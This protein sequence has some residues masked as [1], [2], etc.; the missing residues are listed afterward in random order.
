MAY[1]FD[2]EKVQDD[3]QSMCERHVEIAH[4]VN[5]RK[6]FA[7]F[8]SY[9]EVT[10]IKN[11][12][13]DIV[14]V[15]VS[16]N[17]KR[18]GNKDDRMIQHEMV[19]RIVKFA[20]T[21]GTVIDERNKAIKKAEEIMFDLWTEMEKREEDDIDTL[22]GECSFWR[23]LRPEEMNYEEIEDAP[24]LIN[25]YG[26]DLHVIFRT[27]MP[28]HNAEKWIDE[29]SGIPDD[30]SVSPYSPANL[31]AEFR[32]GAPGAPM[33][34]GSLTYTNS[35]LVNRNFTVLVNGIKIE[36]LTDVDVERYCTK[37]FASDTINFHGGVKN[38]EVVTVYKN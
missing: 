11:K 15:V 19:L 10:E 22:D 18:V 25:H 12:A 36:A 9:E 2:I 37:D 23:F 35:L 26:V 8:M 3:V 28:K 29:A 7:R 34:E 16:F 27:S 31:V 14:V 32:V 30:D 24:W 13:A 17:G 33:T 1:N 20:P 38:G 4:N 5:G 21:I 6:T